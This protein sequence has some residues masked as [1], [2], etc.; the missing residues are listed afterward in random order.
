MAMQLVKYIAH[1]GVCSR[2][3]AAKLV[4]QGLVML[5]GVVVQ[6]LNTLV[7]EHDSVKVNGKIVK[8]RDKVYLML[9]KPLGYLCTNSDEKD[10]KD[11]FDLLPAYKKEKLFT[12]G[13]LDKESSGLLLI[14]N[15]GD[16]AQQLTH[17]SFEIRKEYRIMLDKPMDEKDY[18]RL[19]K[20]VRLK[21]G[22][23]KPDGVI[24]QKSRIHLKIVIHSGKNRI[25]R[26]IFEH[27]GYTVRELT[28]LS[29]GNYELG[30]FPV[31]T[32]RQVSPNILY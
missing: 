26:R 11:V 2:R 7:H 12:V 24:L 9:H 19:Q 1:A 18:V 16:W 4:K 23:I 32:Y 30:K 10:R 27:L 20:G 6:E 25:I 13:R 28:R 3:D 17:P 21:D 8:P 14:T 22:F 5:N 29:F 15:D 31:G